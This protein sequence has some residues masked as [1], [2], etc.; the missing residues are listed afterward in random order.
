MSTDYFDEVVAEVRG[1]QARDPDV[2]L[3]WSWWEGQA[4]RHGMSPNAVYTRA[5]KVGLYVP[6]SKR[7]ERNGESSDAPPAPDLRPDR[8]PAGRAETDPDRVP[9]ELPPDLDRSEPPPSF[10]A[11]GVPPERNG[12]TG[13]RD[14]ARS[15]AV[16]TRFEEAIR[17]FATLLERTTSLERQVDDLKR[18]LE[19][20]RRE[21][22]RLR[23]IL[24]RVEEEIEAARLACRDLDLLDD[25]S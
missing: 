17:G 11:S 12:S 6:P 5:V 2:V 16:G 23:R 8:T 21:N 1:A 9:F 4:D 13:R 10:R 15:S 14:D 3:P 7:S 25:E 24:R 20:T 22:R 18:S 19:D